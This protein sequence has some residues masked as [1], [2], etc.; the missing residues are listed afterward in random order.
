MKLLETDSSDNRSGSL[1]G[2]PLLGGIGGGG[3]CICGEPSAFQN[4]WSKPASERSPF[5]FRPVL[6]FAVGACTCWPLPVSRPPAHLIRVALLIKYDRDAG[7]EL[8]E[9][10]RQER[11]SLMPG[12][13][14][15][16]AVI[17]QY[18][19]PR[20]LLQGLLLCD[21][22]A[23]CLGLTSSLSVNVDSV[24]L[25]SYPWFNQVVFE[26]LMQVWQLVSRK[27][28]Y[29][30]TSP[31]ISSYLRVSFISDRRWNKS[32]NAWGSSRRTIWS[33]A[34]SCEMEFIEIDADLES[35]LDVISEVTEE[36]FRFLADGRLPHIP[37]LIRAVA[38]EES[39]SGI[40]AGCVLSPPCSAEEEHA[41]LSLPVAKARSAGKAAR[42]S[43]PSE[44]ARPPPKHQCQA[45]QWS[46]PCSHSKSLGEWGGSTPP[47]CSGL[48]TQATPWQANWRIPTLER[49]TCLPSLRPHRSTR[50]AGL[51]FTQ[52]RGSCRE[53][54]R[55]GIHRGAH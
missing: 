31:C 6:G 26:D 8:M 38:W 10:W 39:C 13:W 21:E 7:V 50:S 55:N 30:E 4:R 52:R 11:N 27:D 17:S 15:F 32:G 22:L 35:Q 2:P 24:L 25:L 34:S 45:R 43:P 51:N 40:D 19:P 28:E 33:R 54:K 44:V 12:T 29:A 41:G 16:T 49:S 48:G 14:S 3:P 18:G 42:R 46:L 1:F 5:P 36:S 37:S 20:Y 47:P 9:A 53:V 23:A